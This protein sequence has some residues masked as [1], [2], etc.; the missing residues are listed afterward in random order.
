MTAA[1]QSRAPERVVAKNRAASTPPTMGAWFN[2]RAE[3]ELQ[4]EYNTLNRHHLS[5]R[6][7]LGWHGWLKVYHRMQD[8]WAHICARYRKAP[9]SPVVMRALYKA[10]CGAPGA[11]KRL[12]GCFA[13]TIAEVMGDPSMMNFLKDRNGLA[14]RRYYAR[15]GKRFTY[16]LKRAMQR[17]AAE[18]TPEERARLNRLFNEARAARSAGN[19]SPV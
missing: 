2:N 9:F 11:D 19:R 18:E 17:Q 5:L 1:L 3:P 8:E 4:T 15:D 14:R 7:E 6:K 13:F 16:N 10:T 12:D